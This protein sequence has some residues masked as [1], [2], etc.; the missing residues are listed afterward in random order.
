MAFALRQ[1]EGSASVREVCGKMGVSEQTFY[2][3]KKKFAGMDVAGVRR[4]KPLE[5]EK[6]RLNQLI[7]DLSFD[8]Q[9]LQDALK[10]NSMCNLRFDCRRKMVRKTQSAYGVREHRARADQGNSRQRKLVD[11]VPSFEQK[12]VS[13]F[14]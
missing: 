11:V 14:G 5:D 10:G 3:W 12:L 2:R 13:E 9:N 1:A 7:A 6:R 4:F 8:R